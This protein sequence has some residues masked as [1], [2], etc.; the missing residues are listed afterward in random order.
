MHERSKS[1]VTHLDGTLGVRLS[2]VNFIEVWN[3]WERGK[4]RLKTEKRSSETHLAL[5]EAAAEDR[6]LKLLSVETSVQTR[7]LILDVEAAVVVTDGVSWEVRKLVAGGGAR[8]E[9]NATVP[10]RESFGNLSVALSDYGDKGVHGL[11]RAVGGAVGP[12]GVVK[13]VVSV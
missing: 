1:T 10:G 5:V 11:K 4:W 13:V 12:V 7:S 3:L 6:H 9:A 8:E 2:E